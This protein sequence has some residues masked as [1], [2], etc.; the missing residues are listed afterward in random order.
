[1][2]KRFPLSC[3]EA[4]QICA[5]WAKPAL[6][7]GFSWP[8]LQVWTNSGTL[9][10]SA[11][12]QIPSSTGGSWSGSGN[13]NAGDLVISESQFSRAVVEGNTVP[14]MWT[15]YVCTSAITGSATAPWADTAHFGGIPETS[16]I[17]SAVWGGVNQDGMDVNYAGTGSYRVLT[18][19]NVFAGFASGNGT[20]TRQW[21]FGTQYGTW[22]YTGDAYPG[23]AQA[24]MCYYGV[25]A[26]NFGIGGAAGAFYLLPPGGSITWPRFTMLSLPTM[27]AT[28]LT[29]E[30]LAG[31]IQ[32]GYAW[33]SAFS[34][35]TV[36]VTVSSEYTDGDWAADC[37]AIM[38]DAKFAAMA[39]R[40][41]LT[42]TYNAD[43]SISYVGT[44][45]VSP[46]AIVTEAGAVGRPIQWAVAVNDYPTGQSKALVDVC[47]NYCTR[48][49]QS[50]TSGP[51]SC[52]N[53]N[54]DGYAP[55]P[56]ATPGTPGQSAAVYSGQ[57]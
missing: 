18:E 20:V 23:D 24:A 32:S 41:S 43:G 33:P 4:K 38:S 47:G 10:G 42:G 30:F 22:S 49:Y 46:L 51:A 8:S 19:A 21:T 12:W 50:G 40:T 16:G 7:T 44:S 34:T 39:W 3:P 36:T 29:F 1:M 9:T 27:T 37:A 53:G 2:S 11:P 48:T 17:Y 6:F 28:S 55:F 56:L 13:F 25:N 26:A 52:T 45:G 57:C 15:L 31:V 35:V 14:Q 54:V 5:A